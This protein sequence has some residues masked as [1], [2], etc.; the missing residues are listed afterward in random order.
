MGISSSGIGSGLDVNGIVT[1]LMNVERKPLDQVAK[2]KT[3]FESKVS[4]FGTL[5]SSLSTFQTAISS[6]SDPAKFNA[7]AVTSGDT[8]VFT[9]TANG[10]ATNGIS[11]VTVTQ[12]AKAQKLAMAGVANTTDVIGTGTLT[13]SFGKFT[14]ATTTP[15]AAASF[16]PNTAKTDITIDINSAN[17]TLSGVRD[18]INASNSSVSASIVNDGTS[19]RLVITSKDTGE[20]NSLKISVVDADGNSQDAIGLSQMAYDPLATSGNGKNLTQLQAAKNAL[21]DVDGIAISKPS[22]TI[23]DAIQGVT[24]NLIGTS[25]VGTSADLTIATDKEKIKESVKGFVDAYNKLDDTLRNLTKYDPSGKSSGVLLGDA[26][27]RSVINQVKGV[28]TQ[29]IASGNSINSLNQ[30]G[31]SFLGT[32]KLALD[33]TKLSK[34]MDTNFND[35]AAL[36]TTSAKTSD[37]LVSY[38]GSTS[39]TLV[40]TYA[41]NVTQLGSSILN[42]AGTINGVTATGNKTNLTGAFGDA[43]EGLSVTI[44]GGAI[45][46]RGTVTFTRGYASQLDGLISKLL[47]DDGIL[48]AKTD[49]IKSSITRLDKQADA[50]NVRL[51]ATEARYRAQYTRL[52]TL[53]AS[54]QSTSTFL[55]Q[56]IASLSA[57]S[58]S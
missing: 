22:N 43:S 1:S 3:A 20:V 24:L 17:N 49:G 44:A 47:K 18:A 57:N 26:T 13:I 51:A 53:I 50:I 8:K 11:S 37:A 21:L 40:G 32:G 45:G 15:V 39:K 34:T 7:Q 19:N 5:K 56:Q 2:Q 52:D 30:I 28:M 36:F 6:L 27:V 42:A 31:V 16:T 12:L 29:A 48:A 55:T 4:A 9:A 23:T 58:N 33:E 14:E 54:M 25:T 10:Q 38:S 41:V 46:D 35:L